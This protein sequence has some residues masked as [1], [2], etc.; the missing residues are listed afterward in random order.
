MNPFNPILART[1]AGY[2]QSQAFR[3]R[4]MFTGPGA[5]KDSVN[6]VLWMLQR[7]ALDP[8]DVQEALAYLDKSVLYLKFFQVSTPLIPLTAIEDMD[9]VQKL[10]QAILV[11]SQSKMVKA[12]VRTRELRFLRAAHCSKMV[13]AEK[14]RFHDSLA[15]PVSEDFKEARERAQELQDSLIQNYHR[16]SDEIRQRR[17]N[18]LNRISQASAPG[19]LNWHELIQ[20][21]CQEV[22]TEQSDPAHT[23]ELTTH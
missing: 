21:I 20:A 3:E 22:L 16:V 15:W 11:N 13:K 9:D 4:T 14:K 7:I 5:S 19:G 6:V 17:L 10:R 2:H 8:R 18:R 1:P 12:A 23:Q